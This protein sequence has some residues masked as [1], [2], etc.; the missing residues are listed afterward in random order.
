MASSTTKPT[1]TASAISDRLSIEK[2]AAHIAAQV[3]AE[4]QRHRDAG[5]RASPP[6]GAGTANTTSITSTM[7]AASVSCMSCTLARMVCVR[8]ASTEMSSPAGIHCLQL[9]A[10]ARRCGRRSRC[11]LASPCLVMISS[12]DGLLVEPAGRAAVAHARA[13][14]RGDVGQADHRAVDGL[15]HH[16]IVIA[17]RAQLVVD[18]DGGGA[19]VAVEGAERAGGVGIG[20]R[21][22]HVLERDAHGGEP[23]GIDAHADRRLLGA[24]DGHVGDALAPATGAARSRCRRRR[25][26]RSAAASW[27][28]APGSGSAPRTGWTLRKVG[29][30]GM[31]LGRSLS[32]ALSAACT[33]RAA[34]SMLRDEVE[35]HGDAR[36]AE[37]G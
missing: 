19:L 11:T 1:E 36:V 3:P 10:A 31:S 30:V 8:S 28:S 17:G 22:A 12:T 29:S 2:P 9:A 27:R 25:R 21:R 6:A 4:R 37:R 26:S 32:A 35:L 20:D 13:A 23:A 5:G 33:S 18:A 15:H 7:V 16:R 14:T 34:P 24:G